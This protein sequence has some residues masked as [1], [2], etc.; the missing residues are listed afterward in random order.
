MSV[1]CSKED[2]D[3]SKPTPV[4]V[5]SIKL[6]QISVTLFAGETIELTATVSPENATNKTVT[7]SSSNTSVATVTNGKVTAVAIGSTTITAQCGNVKAECTVT[8]S[9]IEVTLIQLN[10]TS[11]TLSAGETVELT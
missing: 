9:P 2:E 5:S 1:A 4:T 3:T 8:V 6:S 7:W 10:K 11:I